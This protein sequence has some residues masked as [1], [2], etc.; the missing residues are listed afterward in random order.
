MAGRLVTPVGEQGAIASQRPIAHARTIARAQCW[1]QRHL[2]RTGRVLRTR[3]FTLIELMVVVVA[4][5]VLAGIAVPSFMAQIRAGRRAEAMATLARIQQ[6][7][8]RWRANCPCYAG[9]LTAASTGGPA[10]DCAGA[11]GLALTFSGPYYRFAMPV[12]PTPATPNSY[13]LAAIGQGNQTGDRAAATSCTT[14][15]ISVTN[16]SAIYAPA[17]CWRQ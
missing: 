9:S 17:A 1:R 14:L 7:Q 16:G 8:E 13:T 10:T 2:A 3:G 15:S 4:L 6:A 12:V 5:A 11:S